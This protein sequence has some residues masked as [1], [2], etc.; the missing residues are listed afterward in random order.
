MYAVFRKL[1]FQLDPE[2]AHHAGL[3]GL[4]VA[5]ALGMIDILSPC[6]WEK[7]TACMNLTFSNPVG[8]AAGLDKDGKYID[9]LGALGFGFIEVGTVT[10][11]PQPGNDKPRLF[12]L[13]EHQAIINRMGFNNE[14]I[15]A[16]VA[17]VQHRKYKGVLGINI[18]KNK[19]TPN[20]EA[21]ND[22]LIC[23]QKAYPVADYIAVNI[24][25]PNTPG[26]RA[27][28]AAE[29]IKSLL[30]RLKDEQAVL[31]Q[32]HGVYRPLAVK[33]A[34]DLDAEAVEEI[35]EIVKAVEMDSI[36]ATNTTV[37][38]EAVAGHKHAAEAG[39]LSG[40]PVRAES[41]RVIAQLSSVLK[42]EVPIIGVG[43]IMSGA[44]AKEKLEA[45]A[46]L[47]QVYSGFIYKGPRLL[48]EIKAACS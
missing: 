44:D 41:S 10:P 15:D 5:R 33:I 4:N 25:S 22:Y 1:L 37:S 19:L 48:N 8:L 16:L 26:L 34:P 40:A 3:K 36:I 35:A 14:G 9:A 18:G 30:S 7:P 28:Q 45:G 46:T 31:E 21:V 6:K 17:R 12:R 11:K 29:E 47:T 24:S 43:G 32:Q 38:R 20:E 13:K 23:M 39:G 2:F 27:L 42:D